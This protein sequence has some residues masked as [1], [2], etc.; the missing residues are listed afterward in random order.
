M[1]SVSVQELG[2][3]AQLPHRFGFST[4]FSIPAGYK[5]TGRAGEGERQRQQQQTT[6]KAE[7]TKSSESRRVIHRRGRQSNVICYLLCAF[8]SSTTKVGR[9]K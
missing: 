5:Q 9:N 7:G 2:R 3:K 8:I 4:M 6:S 1:M